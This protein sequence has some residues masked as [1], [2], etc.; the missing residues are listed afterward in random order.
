MSDTSSRL[1]I[2][3]VVAILLFATIGQLSHHHH[4]SVG[5]YAADALPLLGAWLV[6]ALATGRFLVDVARR[7]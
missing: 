5:G 6:L 3:G 7:R 2:A 4:V 1:A